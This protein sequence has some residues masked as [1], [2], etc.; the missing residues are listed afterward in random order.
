VPAAG[1]SPVLIVT[2][3]PGVG[4]TTAVRILTARSDRAVHLEADAF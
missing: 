3:P 1:D 2:G 4:K